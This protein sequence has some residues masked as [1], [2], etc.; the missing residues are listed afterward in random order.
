MCNRPLKKIIKKILTTP[1]YNYMKYYITQQGLDLLNEVSAKY[2]GTIAGNVV[3]RARNAETTA[4][5]TAAYKSKSAEIKS[6]RK[7]PVFTSTDPNVA[8]T[9]KHVLKKEAQS[10]RIRAKLALRAKYKKVA[11][12]NDPKNRTETQTKAVFD[13]AKD[14]PHSGRASHLE[15][16]ENAHKDA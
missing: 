14:Q 16:P 2:A 9:T 8:K 10:D 13:A 3:R 6:K 15:K 4:R 1:L 5:D 12:E 7:G 11:P